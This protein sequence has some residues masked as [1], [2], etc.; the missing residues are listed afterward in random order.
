MELYEYARPDLMSGKKILYVHGFASSGQTGTVKTMKLLLPN[1][2]IIAPDLPVEPVAALELLKEMCKNEEPDLIIGT[3]MGG[4]FAEMLQG[5]YRIL[6]NPA[7]R[8]ADTILKN[9]GLGKQE[10]HSPRKDGSTSF[11]VT[12]SLLEQFRDVTRLCFQSQ[13]RNHVFGLFGTHDTMTN[14]FDEFSLYYK[15][16]IHFE[17]EHYLNDST[18]LHSVLPVIEWID[19]IQE[20]RQKRVLGVSLEGAIYD[21]RNG[22]PFNGVV[23]SIA[24]LAQ[25]YDLYILI[26]LSPN[27][28]EKVAGKVEWAY[29]HIGVYVWNKIIISAHPE[30]FMGDYIISGEEPVSENFMGT[31]IKYGSEQFRSWDDV[32][33]FFFCFGGQ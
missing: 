17:G 22:E 16:A 15:N 8:L 5:Y 10:Y 20:H 28:P 4:M 32:L 18:F 1:T 21:D 14:C 23:K 2:E 19:D 3:S 11:M 24:K 33:I 30:L 25:M 6:V 13:D 31:V 9:N 29:N 12:K 27:S 26:G 7:F